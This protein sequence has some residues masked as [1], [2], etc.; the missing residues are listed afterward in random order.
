MPPNPPLDIEILMERIRKDL[1]I[2][3]ALAVPK[4]DVNKDQ[5][6]LNGTL[7]QFGTNKNVLPYLTSGWADPEPGLQWTL[8]EVAE[9]NL[10]FEKSPTDLVLTFTAFPL[11]GGGITAQEVSASWNGK[12]IGEWKITEGK[13]FHT[14]ILSHIIA[15]STS[16][17]L[18]FH[19][20]TSF[21]P[22]SR[23][24]SADPRR[25]GLNFQELV[26]RSAAELGFQ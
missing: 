13:S 15:N 19:L 3:R 26:I 9:I 1:A 5:L 24:L 18:R 16:G 23:N 6:Y 14:L 12:L 10:L 20:P 11:I 17:V 22:L 7:L 25:L 8:G 4:S 2:R 21:S